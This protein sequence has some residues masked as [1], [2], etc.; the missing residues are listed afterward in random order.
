MSNGSITRQE[1]GTVGAGITLEELQVVAAAANS[2]HAAW[3][4]PGTER[5]VEILAEVC[6]PDVTYASPVK[7]ADGIQAVAE[8]ITELTTAYPG[9]LPV[10]TSSVDGHHDTARYEWVLRDRAGQAVLGGIEI[11]RF[12]PELRLT[13]LIAF[14]GQPPRITYTYQV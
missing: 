7:R 11:V 13:S 5:R 9:H 14:F 2:V 8:L 6:A 12:N 4:A 1:T 3:A 10:R